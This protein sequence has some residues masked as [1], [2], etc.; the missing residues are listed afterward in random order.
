MEYKQRLQDYIKNMET[1]DIIFVSS[2][3][4][5]HFSDVPDG[6]FFKMVERMTKEGLLMRVSKG[7][8]AKPEA[9][10]EQVENGVLNF[11]FGENNDAG[12]YIGL[13]LYNKYNLTSVT[14]DTRTLYSNLTYQDR[15]IIRNVTI[16]RCPVELTYDHA[17]IIEILE[18]LEHYKDIPK[19]DK[20]QFA[21]FLV[22]MS[23]AYDDES[24]RQ[25]LGVM[26]Y[27]K[28]TIAFL[29]SVLDEYKV[30]NT[31]SVYLNKASKYRIPKL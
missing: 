18:V 16:Y 4:E 26:K 21:R 1:D 9:T 30:P 15:K 20:K 27:R 31:M 7:I 22:Q 23:K 3:Y 28:S 10:E 19:L 2:L 25:V 17:K 11:Y 12:M 24:A 14:D 29:K 5:E 8:Y 13:K 6:A